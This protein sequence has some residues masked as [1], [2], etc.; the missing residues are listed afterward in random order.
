MPATYT[1]IRYP[2]GKTKLYPLIKDII[3][4]NGYTDRTY[5]EAFAGGA[6]AAVKLLLKGDVSSIL[7][8]DLDRAVYCMWDCIVNRS[9]AL[10]AFIDDV[11][12]TIENWKRF[13]EVYNHP[14]SA[15]DDELGRASFF[16]NR[17]NV[18]GILDG[19]VIGGMGQTGT[20]PID[21]RFSK[22]GLKAKIRAIAEKRDSIELYMMDAGDLIAK[23][24]E[25]R[26][27]H[28]FCYF[29]PPYVQKGPGL[30][31]SA[32]DEQKHTD[33]ARKILN[34]SF[35]WMVTYDDDALVRRLYKGRLRDTLI[36]DYSANVHGKGTERLILRK[37]MRYKKAN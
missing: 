27:N 8:N 21:A 32:F 22:D 23:V 2:G 24:L 30:Y 33:L 37:G 4:R 20:Y 13:R 1:P 11:D 5:C 26:S 28:V 25:P 36:L 17:T 34:S 29:D 7:I 3:D 12:V 14:D 10:C 18:S 6:G 31:R 15:S 19:G 16:L 35:P 9:D